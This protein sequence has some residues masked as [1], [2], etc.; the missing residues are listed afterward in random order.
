M[1]IVLII[2][3]AFACLPAASAQNAAGVFGPVVDEN[4]RQLEFRW[5]IAEPDDGLTPWVQRAHWEQ[6]LSDRL[7][8]R[9]GVQ[10]RDRSSSSDVELDFVRGMLF[11]EAG[12]PTENWT[13]GFRFDARA[14]NGSRPDELALSWTNQYALGPSTFARF[15]VMSFFQIGDSAPDNPIIETRSTVVKRLREGRSVAL[16]LYNVYGE[17]GQFGGW[18][19]QRHELAPVYSTPIFNGYY[20]W[21]SIAVGLSEPVPD[22][23]L[24]FRVGKRF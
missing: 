13:T 24:R 8:Y 14:R 1:R 12:Q 4:T 7:S 18:S 6:G 10:W 20:L 19:D 22:Y 3:L 23:T 2:L 9:L 5:S 16:E 11:F 21:S 15:N 17:F